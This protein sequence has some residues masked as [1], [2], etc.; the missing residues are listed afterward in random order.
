MTMEETRIYK[1][2]TIRV[3]WN[4]ED[5]QWYFCITDILSILLKQED[6]RAEWRKRKKKH[7]EIEMFCFGIRMLD[8]DD[9]QRI[10]ECANK[11]GILRILNTLPESIENELFKVWLAKI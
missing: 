6:S 8:T 2:H 1:G 4:K 10:I 7:P 5:M 3:R 9:R 11:Y